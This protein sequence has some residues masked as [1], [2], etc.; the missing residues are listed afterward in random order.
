MLS[1]SIVKK[2]DNISEIYTHF[3]RDKNETDTRRN[4][5]FE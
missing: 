5:N 2:S 4:V 1:T 3:S